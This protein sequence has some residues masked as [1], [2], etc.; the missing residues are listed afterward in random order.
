MMMRTRGFTL[1][2]L[3]VVLAIIIILTSCAYVM[4]PTRSLMQEFVYQAQCKANLKGIGTAIAMYKGEGDDTFPLLWTTGQ[5]E[6]DITGLRSWRS[7]SCTAREGV[8]SVRTGQS[9]A[10]S[11]ERSSWR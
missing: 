6:A 11:F 9:G 3:V 2:D 4:I 1:G 5:P 7:P 8:A 10:L